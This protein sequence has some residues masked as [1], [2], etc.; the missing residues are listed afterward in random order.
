M[1]VGK[2]DKKAKVKFTHMPINYVYSQ[3]SDIVSKNQFK[4][5]SMRDLDSRLFLNFK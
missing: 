1:L 4:V 3:I 2:Q 5:E